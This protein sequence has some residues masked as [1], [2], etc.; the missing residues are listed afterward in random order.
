MQTKQRQML[1][2]LIN[3]YYR[4]SAE[5]LMAGMA[6]EDVDAVTS[7]PLTMADPAAAIILPEKCISNS[8][9]YS[10]FGELIQ[11]MSSQ[12]QPLYISVLPQNVIPR[13][14]QQINS[15]EPLHTPSP[16][17]K[18]YLS[19]LLVKK[20]QITDITPIAF[21]P[22][23]PLTTLASFPKE[24]L[25]LIADF[26]S[27]H[28]L[29]EEIKTILD[30]HKLQKIY[31]C[32][33]TPQQQYLKT[34]LHQKTKSQSP[35]IGLA[36]WQGNEEELKRL[37]HRRGLQRLA[38]ALSGHN[39]D[40]LWH[41]THRLD[42]GRGRIIEKNFSSKEIPQT[43]LPMRQHVINIINIFKKSG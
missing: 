10:W 2:A 29:G 27:L 9:H 20:I 16:I 1:R 3:C 5:T 17:A 36:N 38:Y 22:A 14:Q 37:L 43:T 28:D 35:K 31:N 39:Q 18:K 24:Q 19:T 13:V 12:L 34:C 7:L 21:L 42:T 26:L 41:I 4:G 11:N 23:E 30:T 32:L 25:I 15:K 40:L 6:K 33:S 8:I